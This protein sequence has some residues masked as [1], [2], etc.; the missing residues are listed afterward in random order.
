MTGVVR[1][2]QGVTDLPLQI[3]TSDRA[4]HGARAMRLYNGKPL[5]NSVNGKQEVHG[6]GRSRW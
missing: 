5:V 1:A 4:G 6:H 3:D 2:L